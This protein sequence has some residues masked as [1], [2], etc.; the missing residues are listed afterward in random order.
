MNRD[1]VNVACPLI[2]CEDVIRKDITI[3]C[4]IIVSSPMTTHTQLTATV[5]IAVITIAYLTIN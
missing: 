5:I 4:T 2:I 1:V 3:G